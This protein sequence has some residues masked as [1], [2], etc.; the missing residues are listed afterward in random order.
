MGG[1]EQAS[2]ESEGE[3]IH[4]RRD[5]DA[6]DDDEDMIT[7]PPLNLPKSAL[8]KLGRDRRRRAADDRKD[9]KDIGAG[10]DDARGQEDL[11]V[12]DDVDGKGHLSYS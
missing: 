9:V 5:G 2:D 6:E 7:L 3:G 10:V 11:M 12:I 4:H 1:S 8:D